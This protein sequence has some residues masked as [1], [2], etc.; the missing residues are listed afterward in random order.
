MVSVTAGRISS[1][2]VC[3]LTF[4]IMCSV[5]S[6]GASFATYYWFLFTRTYGRGVMTMQA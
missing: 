1:T 2:Q 6:V 4:V 3:N 5:F